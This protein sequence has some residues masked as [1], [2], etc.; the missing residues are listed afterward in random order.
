MMYSLS[1]H[2]AGFSPPTFPGSRRRCPGC[3]SASAERR[4]TVIATMIHVLA[5]VRVKPQ[6]L[7]AALAC[8]RAFVP[9]V[10]ANEPGC[11]EYTPT[12][13]CDL[14]LRNQQEIDAW[15]D[16]CPIK[17]FGDFLV[18]AKIMTRAEVERV[19]QEACGEVEQAVAY[20][21]ASPYPDAADVTKNVYRGASQ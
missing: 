14:G 10:I 7:A 3:S 5:F 8:Y 12:V 9:R 21:L 20:S 2:T 13:D 6:A 17:H 11:L 19:W 18:D 16:R 4:L 15:K 1:I